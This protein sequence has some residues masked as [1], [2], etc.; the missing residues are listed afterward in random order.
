MSKVT[1]ALDRRPDKRL[2]INTLL[3]LLLA[4]KPQILD[5]FFKP[6]IPDLG[7]DF[8]GSDPPVTQGT[9]DQVEVVGLL[10]KAGSERVPEG[11]NGVVFPDPGLLEPQA[12]PEFHLPGPDP[13]TSPGKEQRFTRPRWIVLD[14]GFQKLFQWAVQEDDL[15]D[16][17]LSVYPEDSLAEINMISVESHQG[18]ES[19]TG[20][21]E[22]GKNNLVPFGDGGLL[23]LEGFYKGLDFGIGHRSRW[24]SRVTCH[25]DQSGWIGLQVTAVSEESE[26]RSEDGLGAILGDDCLWCSVFC[27]SECCRS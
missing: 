17:V 6:G 1:M 20:S 13:I 21:Q 24:F 4:L 11:V 10:V 12:K 19:N 22:E 2:K 23:G 27:Q 7:V 14:I 3:G 25:P 16:A 15:L 5:R 18:A 26:E 8:G 9:L